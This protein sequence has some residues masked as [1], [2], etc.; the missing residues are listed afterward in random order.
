MFVTVWQGLEPSAQ[1]CPRVAFP[2]GMLF[3]LQFTLVF[4]VP[5][6]CVLTVTRWFDASVAVAGETITLTPA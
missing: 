5:L 3:T 1:I 6:T 4:E 2:P